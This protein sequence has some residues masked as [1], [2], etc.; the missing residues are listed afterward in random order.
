MAF[1]TNTSQDAAAELKG[2][3]LYG[4]LAQELSYTALS[5]WKS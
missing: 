3:N 2:L 4:R 5:P 1:I